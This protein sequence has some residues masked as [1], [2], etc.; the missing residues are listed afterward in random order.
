M[1]KRT[2]VDPKKSA[3]LFDKTE[4]EQPQ[5]ETQANPVKAYGVGLR[6]SEW[7]QIE[8]IAGEMGMTKHALAAYA[9][10]DFLK[11]WEAGEI[12]TE[13]KPSLPELD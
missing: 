13:T 2:G 3:G 11:R 1:A 10:K 5:E 12:Q 4:S 7:Q 6:V 9:L 8:T